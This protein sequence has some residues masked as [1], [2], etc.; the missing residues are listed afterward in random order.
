MA[1]DWLLSICII[2]VCCLRLQIITFFCT[3]AF[4]IVPFLPSH[5]LKLLLKFQIQPQI[6]SLFYSFH[7][8][9][10]LLLLSFA[11][12]HSIP[13]SCG[14]NFLSA[15]LIHDVSYALMAIV[16]AL[17]VFNQL[18]KFFY[19]AQENRFQL[20]VLFF[21]INVVV[22]K[23]GPCTAYV[24]GIDLYKKSFLIAVIR[25]SSNSDPSLNLL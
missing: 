5:F 14:R 18:P 15:I 23:S 4:T 20:L 6:V 3:A 2:T 25:C 7:D 10:P 11:F 16:I 22:T 9:H 13:S 1:I 12:S 19:F 8:A 17:I 24:S 21:V